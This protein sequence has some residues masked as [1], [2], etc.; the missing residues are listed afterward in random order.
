VGADADLVLL[1]RDLEIDAVLAMGRF[2]VKD[3]ELKC[4]GT[5]EQDLMDGLDAKR[6]FGF[7]ASGRRV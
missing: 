6:P 3:H 7:A 4:L 5:F 2:M 1:D